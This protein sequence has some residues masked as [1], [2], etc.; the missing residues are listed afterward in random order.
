MKNGVIVSA[1]KMTL[2]VAVAV[3]VPATLKLA[4]GLLASA[5]DQTR[6]TEVNPHHNI[7][8]CVCLC[9]SKVALY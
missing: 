9:S 8:F 3:A 4:V 1:V 7:L 6:A 2:A 5:I